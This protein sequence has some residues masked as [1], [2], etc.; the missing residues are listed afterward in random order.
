MTV[1][2]IVS[3]STFLAFQAVVVALPFYLNS[4]KFRSTALAR[5]VARITFFSVS[6]SVEAPTILRIGSYLLAYWSLDS[7]LPTVVAFIIVVAV[8]MA[9]SEFLR[10][11]EAR[12]STDAH[13]A[14]LQLA[15][16]EV[17]FLN[18]KN[19]IDALGNAIT[20]EIR[21]LEERQQLRKFLETEIAKKEE[22]HRAWLLLSEEQREY[23]VR[24][25]HEFAPPRGSLRDW[26]FFGFGIIGNIIAS[27]IWALAGNPGK[28]EVLDLWQRLLHAIHLA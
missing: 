2:E 20:N 5:R 3:I 8:V 27:A 22:E 17:N 19:Q 11:Q 4:P 21:N 18:A 6:F 10:F 26:V 28:Q 9:T 23:F 16:V 13:D 1:T 12:P 25:A 14:L 7:L 24:K 15:R